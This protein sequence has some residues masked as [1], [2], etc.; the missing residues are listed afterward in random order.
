MKIKCIIVDDEPLAQDLLKDYI[1]KVSFLD[2]RATCKSA[3]EASKLILDQ[4]IDLIFLDIHMP[5]ISGID[6]IKNNDHLPEIIFTTAYS[7]YALEGFEYKAIDYLLKPFSFE[8]FHK[9]ALRAYEISSMKSRTYE[10]REERN[11]I[12]VKSEYKLVKIAF[13]NVLYIEGLKDYIKIVT[14]EKTVLTLMRMKDIE[15]KLPKNTF[16]RIHR[17]FIIS[18]NNVDT[19]NKTNVCIGKKIIPVTDHYKDNFYMFIDSNT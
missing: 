16:I 9:A 2:L 18:I 13:D 15:A 14:K 7:H 4:K 12:F 17:S 6:F 1:E 11:Y 10:K 5:E 19:I 8:R 3:L